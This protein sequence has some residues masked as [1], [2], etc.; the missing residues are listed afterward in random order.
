M[1]NI[2]ITSSNKEMA[3]E[4]VLKVMATVP[5]VQGESGRDFYSTFKAV[6]TLPQ[7]TEFLTK[8]DEFVNDKEGGKDSM[9]HSRLVTGY[10]I[11]TIPD[12]CISLMK[13]VAPAVG[14]C[15]KREEGRNVPDLSG[16]PTARASFNL[17]GTPKGNLTAALMYVYIF[18]M[19]AA[20]PKI[21]RDLELEVMDLQSSLTQAFAD[22]DGVADKSVK[23][24][25]K[26]IQKELDCVLA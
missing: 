8:A 17:I 18:R 4:S 19:L 13:Q 9:S 10:G 16:S 20:V 5:V 11:K 25:A 14:V 2:Q 21:S 12:E 7:V 6:L 26:K 15:V 1:Q 24:R 22:I 3:L 23:A